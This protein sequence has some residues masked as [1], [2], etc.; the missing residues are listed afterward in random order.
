MPV[1]KI[2][3]ASRDINYAEEVLLSDGEIFDNE[4]RTFIS[5]LR[6]LDLQAV[7]GSGKT[8]ALLAKL[9]ILEKLLPFTD[10]SGVLVI[11]HTNASI[12]EI[13]SKIGKHAPR[14]FSYPNFVGTIQS[15][16][17]RL[18]AIPFYANKYNRKLIRI[19]NEIYYQHHYVPG[20]ASAYLNNRSD[21]DDILFNSRLFGDN[22]LRYGFTSKAFPLRNRENTTYKALVD[23]K[24]LLREKGYLCFDDAYI[25]ASQYIQEIPRIKTILQKRFR[26]VFVDEIQ[27]MARHQHDILEQLFFSS[28]NSMSV[29]QRIGDK[30]QAI[31]NGEITLE[32]VWDDRDI[33]LKLS[34]SYRF[35]PKIANVVKYFALCPTEIEG[36][37]KYSDG[38]E[39]EIKPHMIVFDDASRNQ[40][41]HCFSEIIQDL[42]SSSKLP[43]NPNH[44]FKVIAWRKEHEES[45]KLGLKDYY[46]HFEEETHSPKIDHTNLAS[47]LNICIKKKQTLD[48]VRKSILNAFLKILRLENISDQSDR[49]FTKRKLLSYLRDEHPETYELFKLKLYQWSIGLIRDKPDDV[50]SDIKAYTPQ[51]LI[52]FGKE[53]DLSHSF[54]VG[55]SVNSTQ[56]SSG[57]NSVNNTNIYKNEDTEIIV[58]TVHSSKG[59]THTATLYLETYYYQDGRGIN[60]KSYE[61]QRLCQQFKNNFIPT[62]AGV[63]VKQSA[64]MVYVGI[65]RPTHLL[66]FAVHKDRFDRYLNDLD[67]TVWEIIKV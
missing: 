28:G 33:I 35:H 46:Q 65:S 57:D 45:D 41:I 10:G 18:L 17:D 62:M 2:E 5:D 16:V 20:R 58:T 13:K 9:L 23:L 3:I 54:I 6:T 60:A 51:V 7:P 37:R 56:T 1:D 31:F 49:V 29:F 15:F 63:R 34:G 66:C 8:T 19:D 40:V 24:V 4:R 59:Q 48:F 43:S 44:G 25:L 52:C 42:K 26:F 12:D 30:N 22:E 14:L 27:D 38:T 64:R 55:D 53:I 11:S 39:I 50:L 47:Y 67:D 61:S 21:K 32:D 36:R